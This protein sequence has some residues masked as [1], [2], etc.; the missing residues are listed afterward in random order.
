MNHLATLGEL[1][2]AWN[3]GNVQLFNKVAA[4][5][6]QQTGNQTPTNLKAAVTMV[7]PEITKAVV[8]AGGGVEDRKKTDQALNLIASSPAQAVGTIKTMQELMAG[9]LSEV[10]RT[11]K[12]STKRS[13]F[14]DTFLSPAS[15]ELL[16]ARDR[17]SVV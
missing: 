8:G 7:G 12:R 17:K 3:S 11:Y 1:A 5:W 9:R 16:D 13:D 6:G 2:T 15:K 4:F 10:E 14:R